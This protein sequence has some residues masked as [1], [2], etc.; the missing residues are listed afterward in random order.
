MA[1]KRALILP[2]RVIN[3]GSVKLTLFRVLFPIG[4]LVS[5][6]L[7]L[8]STFAEGDSVGSAGGTRYSQIRMLQRSV[9]L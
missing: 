9:L 3:R 2:A 8:I 5:N 6:F 1:V 7:P 4:M